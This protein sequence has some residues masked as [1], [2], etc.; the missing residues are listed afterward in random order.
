MLKLCIGAWAL[1]GRERPARGMAV[2]N[3]L[4]LL[5]SRKLRKGE[6]P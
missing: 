3:T 6:T 2:E 4:M 1:L 5:R